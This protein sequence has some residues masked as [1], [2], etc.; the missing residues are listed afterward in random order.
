MDIVPIFKES[1]GLNNRVNQTRVSYAPESGASD[2]ARAVNITH[3]ATGRPSRR[4]GCRVLQ[5]GSYHSAFCDGGDCFVGRG[6]DLYRV[7]TDFS[8][9][10]VRTGLKGSRIGFCQVGEDTYYGNGF[11]NGVIKGGQS[12][13]WPSGKYEG[14]ETARQFSEAPIGTHIAVFNG[15][16][17]ISQGSNVWISEPWAPGLFNRAEGF[18]SFRSQVRMVR[19]V[20]AGVFISDSKDTWFF[21][22]QSSKDFIQTKVASFPVLEWSDAIDSIDGFDAGLETPGDCVLWGSIKGA[23]LG[24][25]E[26]SV[27]NLNGKKLNYPNLGSQ[28]SRVLIG[29]NF[30]HSI[31]F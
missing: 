12:F 13:P 4:K 29:T 10:G 14:P 20:D 15:S 8:L 19:P 23:I 21:S 2:L 26:G 27:I 1:L 9:S 18:L 11:Q 30:I 7:G 17:F 25:P 16:W 28:G 5:N 22:G 6:S 24:T 3:D 31:F